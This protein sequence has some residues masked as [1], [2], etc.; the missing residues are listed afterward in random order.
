M[1]SYDRTW[2]R[3]SMTSKSELLGVNRLGAYLVGWHRFDRDWLVILVLAPVAGE[4]SIVEVH[5]EPM[6]AHATP[7]AL[8][9][10]MLERFRHLADRDRP[11]QGMNAGTL[12]RIPLGTMAAE[13]GERQRET[14]ALGA[15]HHG[16]RFVIEMPAGKGSLGVATPADLFQLLD[17]FTAARYVELAQSGRPR[18]LEQLAEEFGVSVSGVRA[19]LARARRAGLMTPARRGV[20]GGELT[21]LG[22]QL[23]EQ[24][25]RPDQPAAVSDR[26]AKIPPGTKLVGRA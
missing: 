7:A 4:A 10:Q 5:V 26:L 22:R 24:A 15:R 17:L 14:D 2:Y 21:D 6:P 18:L 8:S 20:A 16:S 1:A 11:T 3:V 23:I 25:A 9:G 12:R 19:R 13:I